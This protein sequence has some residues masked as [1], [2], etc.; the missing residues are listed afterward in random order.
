MDDT[1]SPTKAQ[2]QS[3]TSATYIPTYRYKAAAPTKL[4]ERR[5]RHPSDVG[6]SSQ[7]EGES[8]LS[9][10]QIP[11]GGTPLKTK[12]PSRREKKDAPK[13]KQPSALPPPATRASHA[14]SRRNQL[15]GSI[16]LEGKGGW[17]TKRHVIRVTD[18]EQKACF[19]SVLEPVSCIIVRQTTDKSSPLLFILLNRSRRSTFRPPF[20]PPV[21]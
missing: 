4:H 9:V 3:P 19:H 6:Q 10:R 11:A 13:A 17:V 2:S 8:L 5:P 7:R 15:A 12:I 16:G 21:P 20:G 1:Q 14:A 18:D